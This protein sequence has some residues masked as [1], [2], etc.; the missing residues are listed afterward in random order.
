M[1]MRDLRHYTCYGLGMESELP[2]P[3]PESPKVG[4][5]PD[6]SVRVGGF[7]A[8]VEAGALPYDV[9]GAVY[10]PYEGGILIRAKG[11][12]DFMVTSSSIRV[13]KGAESEADLGDLVV[14]M[15]LGFALQLRSMLAFHGSAASRD[16]RAIAIFGQRGSGKSTTVLGLTK[17]GW[18]LLCDDILVVEPEGTL[19][20]GPSRARLN[21]DSYERLMDV[22]TAAG[23]PIDRDGKHPVESGIEARAAPLRTV[24]AL[25]A[26]D[27]ECVDARQRRGYAKLTVALEHMHSPPG[28]GEPGAR[29]HRAAAALARVPLYE[30]RRPARRFALEELLDTIEAF[31]FP[32]DP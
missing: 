6:I 29:L 21:A 14:R 16:G 27:V 30:I 25:M 24:F 12:A 13:A 2:L 4:T 20:R 31:S 1:R 5:L 17:R 26:A 23:A 15:A 9:G 11:V 22:R 8:P 3:L 10:G 28:I 19:P 7:E 32:E 18:G